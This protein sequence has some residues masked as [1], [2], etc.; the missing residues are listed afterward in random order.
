M[1]PHIWISNDTDHQSQR[2][3]IKDGSTVKNAI[4]IDDDE[5]DG[6][7]QPSNN[8]TGAL[9]AGVFKPPVVD[10]TGNSATPP[11][12]HPPEHIAELPGSEVPVQASQRTYTLSWG[13]YTQPSERAPPLATNDE[14]PDTA[15]NSTISSQ[16]KPS[17]QPQE[18]NGSVDRPTPQR[19]NSRPRARERS[20]QLRAGSIR[21]SVS[22]SDARLW[23]DDV[24]VI[25]QPSPAPFE[26]DAERWC[27]EGK[28]VLCP[29]QNGIESHSTAYGMRKIDGVTTYGCF[30]GQNDIGCGVTVSVM[31]YKTMVLIH[32]MRVGIRDKG[33][34]DG[35][36]DDAMTGI[37][38]TV[39]GAGPVNQP[40]QSGQG[41]SGLDS[42]KSPLEPSTLDTTE[43]T[44]AGTENGA[45][46]SPVP[47]PVAPADKPDVEV[48]PV[49]DEFVLPPIDGPSATKPASDSLQDIVE[50]IR[51][52][53]TSGAVELPA[54]LEA[55]IELPPMDIEPETTIQPALTLP[56]IAPTITSLD[57]NSHEANSPTLDVPVTKDSVSSE[58][59][60]A[61]QPSKSPL[62]PSS[63]PVLE[64]TTTTEPTD[65]PAPPLPPATEQS[66]PKLPESPKPS[67]SSEPPT[68]PPR[69][70]RRKRRHPS[71]SLLTKYPPP[72]PLDLSSEITPV[73]PSKPIESMPLPPSTRQSVES[74]PPQPPPPP[75]PRT[76][77][78]THEPPVTRSSANKDVCVGCKRAK[79]AL[80]G[81]NP[82][83]CQTCKRA[84]HRSCNADLRDVD[85][86][87]TRWTCRSC[88]PRKPNTR[89]S[90]GTS[91]SG[92]TTSTRKSSR[93]SLGSSKGGGGHH[94]LGMFKKHKKDEV[95][96]PSPTGPSITLASP[97]ISVTREKDGEVAQEITKDAWV[98]SRRK[99][100]RS[101]SPRREEGVGGGMRVRE[102]SGMASS[103]AR[104]TRGSS[105]YQ[106]RNKSPLPS[107]R[108]EGN[109]EKE[110]GE[111]EGEGNLRTRTRRGARS[112]EDNLERDLREKYRG[113]GF[114]AGTRPVRRRHVSP[115][116]EPE[117]V[118]SVE[119]REA[120][121]V[122]DVEPPSKRRR[123]ESPS[124]VRD[125]EV[126]GEEPS[127]ANEEPVAVDEE[128]A[129][130]EEEPIVE[131]EPV[132]EEESMAVDEEPIA[133]EE[134]PIAAEE[135]PIAAEEESMAVEKE[136]LAVEEEPIAVEEESM[137]LDDEPTAVNGTDQSKQRGM[138]GYRVAGITLVE[139]KKVPTKDPEQPED[140]IPVPV[141][142]YKAS[143]AP[144]TSTGSKIGKFQP[145]P[146]KSLMRLSDRIITSGTTL[147]PPRS[148]EP[149]TPTLPERPRTP[150][151]QAGISS[152][153]L[154]TNPLLPLTEFLPIDMPCEIRAL[155]TSG[156]VSRIPDLRSLDIEVEL[157]RSRDDYQVA[158]ER[159]K[160]LEAEIERYESQ[161]GGLDDVQLKYKAQNEELE[162]S[163]AECLKLK[164][165]VAKGTAQTDRMLQRLEDQQAGE[166]VKL[167][168][169]NERCER[170]RSSAE[171]ATEECERLKH[172]V[173]VLERQVGE[174][175]GNTEV[176]RELRGQLVEAK[177][178]YEK[179]EKEVE[180]LK[181]KV[182]ELEG[183]RKHS[184]DL[185]K[186]LDKSEDRYKQTMKETEGQAKRF[187]KAIDEKDRLARDLDQ[188]RWNASLETKV[189]DD[190][191]QKLEKERGRCKA[192]EEKVSGLK[193]QATRP[194][195]DWGSANIGPGPGGYTDNWRKMED[196]KEKYA[197][198]QKNHQESQQNLMRLEAD[199]V[200][201]ERL[202]DNL[203]V[204][205]GRQDRK[206]LRLESE[207]T[208][209]KEKIKDA[210][211]GKEE[212]DKELEK[213]KALRTVFET[214]VIAKDAEVEK[215]KKLNQEAREKMQRDQAELEDLKSSN[216]A[217]KMLNDHYDEELRSHKAEVENAQQKIKAVEDGFNEKITSLISS[218]HQAARDLLSVNEGLRAQNDAHTEE[219]LETKALQDEIERRKEV[220]RSLLERL[221]AA[222]KR[223]RELEGGINESR[224]S[225][226][227]SSPV[228]SEEDDFESW[229]K[230]SHPMLPEP[231][232]EVD[233]VGDLPEGHKV[234]TSQPWKERYEAWYNR[235]PR[236]LHLHRSCKR[237]LPR[238]E[239][240]V[241][242]F[243]VDGSAC[244]SE[245]DEV[246]LRGR[247]RKRGPMTFDEFRGVEQNEVVP[248][249]LEKC[250][251]VV[252]RKAE[253][254]RR[255]GG[256]SRH[257]IIY[258]TGRNVPGELRG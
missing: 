141:D 103:S 175:L 136:P 102:K 143:T 93:Y 119:E 52:E 79:G 121:P 159:C 204:I 3:A 150:E 65:T 250:S 155:E 87:V 58:N 178:R 170:Y 137:V 55:P 105:S 189:I 190:L 5:D 19:H 63:T 245:D 20:G 219:A 120:T 127:A 179:A 56:S 237:D 173:E 124:A 221:E 191:T 193:E 183:L 92:T 253:K 122:A 90:G 197:E 172:Q 164:G 222:E 252:F 210:W 112:Q 165:D 78:K 130:V 39:D 217:Y 192:L 134:E 158:K 200:K 49:I 174:S 73:T 88:K 151:Q 118:R 246:D 35:S 62:P 248:V 162:K 242:I 243:E 77:E 206:C 153:V 156:G 214:E 50:P 70:V 108:S 256:L 195:P 234:R 96:R 226:T 98:E 30:P 123:Q 249:A 60:E 215:L 26:V 251:K 258:K 225:P 91:S 149:E 207:N 21:R 15:A 216:L 125:E 152:H 199:F 13:N 163:K 229:F 95:R 232:I 28:L 76:A 101:V 239:G 27:K 46:G 12:S 99:R 8:Q 45:S 138:N 66:S 254:N 228:G 168:T 154:E 18:R 148:Q 9:A 218:H 231:G 209:L 142:G 44:T 115:S 61:P 40:E 135:E 224:K 10:L 25:S 227:P 16:D 171:K 146:R 42:A 114:L 29:G 160:V 235:N 11:A 6:D 126:V 176:A 97:T 47:A 51:A 244:R 72:R 71:P 147:Q 36:D 83:R 110:N 33:N 24:E 128:P 184:E 68:S 106:T 37:E 113:N 57:G 180:V 117:L 255:T 64:T 82:V 212:V 38:A 2:L 157:R 1:A 132:A 107:R 139:P 48:L 14:L 59:L 198:L 161:T 67:R 202:K 169:V 69:R 7:V 166:A 213:T 187:N 131:Q 100:N 80:P 257:A 140:D 23:E 41:G 182:V 129:A 181:V 236:A 233:A 144:P 84:W 196:L 211:K 4:V 111:E 109:N 177:I 208:T 85:Y 240:E 205:R 185:Q 247:T 188:A 194:W 53:D 31:E 203:Y 74:V 75:P 241:K 94:G 230:V 22:A 104:K 145:L 133:A 89:S 17:S 223:C 167:A 238:I 32:L 43:T 116:V 220:E 54:E 86:N 34:K 186:K 81:D 201:M